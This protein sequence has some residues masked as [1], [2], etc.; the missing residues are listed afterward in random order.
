MAKPTG[1]ISNLDRSYCSFLEEELYPGSAFRMSAEAQEACIRQVLEA[2]PTMPEV[3]V[4]WQGGEPTMMGL[5]FFC[6]SIELEQ[7]YARPGQRILNAIQ[8]NGTLLD[9][10]RG[11]FLRAYD[12]LVGISID[13]P[14]EMHDAYRAD[15]GSMPTFDRVIGGLDVL[16]RH[17]VD[18]NVLTA[19]HAANVDFGADVYRFLRDDL[20]AEFIQLIPIVERDSEVA[21]GVTGRSVRPEQFGRFM[22]EVFDEWMQH[23]IGRVYVQMFDSALADC[24]GEPGS[25]GEPGQHH[26]CAGYEQFFRHVGEPMEAMAQLRREGRPP[27][28]LLP[29]QR[30]TVTAYAATG[31]TTP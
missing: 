20:E 23:D 18:W 17:G 11:S 8:T 16:K 30:A 15:N 28:E 4:T 14:R 29:W 26:L 3:V 7:R 21:S 24:Y 9:D 13:G 27:A 25:N 2:H 31:R 5:E 19:V 22:V 10:D 1:A 6:R 12:F